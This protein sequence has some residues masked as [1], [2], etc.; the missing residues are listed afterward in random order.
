MVV[1]IVRSVSQE[2]A[3]PQTDATEMVQDALFEEITSPE[4]D[5]E[6]STHLQKP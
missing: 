1:K 5:A 2:D 6:E 4:R 3:R